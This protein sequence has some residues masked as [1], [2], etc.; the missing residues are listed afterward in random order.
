MDFSRVWEGFGFFGE[1]RWL[2]EDLVG[3]GVEG[4][5]GGVVGW[6]RSVPLRGFGGLEG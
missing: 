1:F 4:F 3:L 5:R 2:F 6:G